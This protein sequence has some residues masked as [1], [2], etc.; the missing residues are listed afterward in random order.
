[1]TGVAID[2]VVK[3]N[4]TAAD[5]TTAAGKWLAPGTAGVGQNN[6]IMIMSAV[7]TASN[8]VKV[9]FSNMI[10]DTTPSIEGLHLVVGFSR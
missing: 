5:Y 8:T 2:D 6:G 3:V 4:Y 7:A 10:A 9:T 1:V